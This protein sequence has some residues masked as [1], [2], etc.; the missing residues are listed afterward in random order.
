MSQEIQGFRFRT[1]ARVPYGE[2]VRLRFDRSGGSV[3]AV[4]SDLSIEGMFVATRESRPVG[5]VVEFEI[6]G[7][8][9][10]T[11]RG[12]SDVVWTRDD[13]I[14]PGRHAG[15]GL[16]FRYVDPVSRELIADMVRRRHEESAAGA[17]GEAAAEEQVLSAVAGAGASA[18]RRTDPLLVTADVVLA[19]R[20][21]GVASEPARS[22][23]RGGAEAAPEVVARARPVWV[24]GLAALL[25]VA[26]VAV[27]GW[28]ML[29]GRSSRTSPSPAAATVSNRP[30]PPAMSAAP[31]PGSAPVV[32][33][34]TLDSTDDSSALIAVRFERAP[35]PS[36]VRV[37]R[38]DGPPRLLVRVRGADGAPGAR[39]DSRLVRGMQ[40]TVEMTDG[41][42]E[43][44]LAF[45]LASGSVR[46]DWRFEEDRLLLRLL[47]E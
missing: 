8:E 9:G 3:T 12:L 21:A 14:G 4:C 43:L 33:A 6:E 31:G 11:A 38:L 47:D 42:P 36:L 45:E 35:D 25:L 1:S 23:S 39:L 34:V 29:R 32:A 27:L 19:D 22:P 41:A 40:S 5:T 7:P 44:H 18:T 13:A 16:Q 37:T 20:A 46:A 28:S 26:A 15:M 2:K 17:E 10:R 30:A 24:W